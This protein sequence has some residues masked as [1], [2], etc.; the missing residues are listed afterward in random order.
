MMCK[1]QNIVCNAYSTSTFLII[2]NVINN[3]ISISGI[4]NWFAIV[5]VVIKINFVNIFTMLR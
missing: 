1:V 2:G 4:C 5:F 3:D